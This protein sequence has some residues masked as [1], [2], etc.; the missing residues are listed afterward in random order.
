MLK[1]EKKPD[2]LP[3]VRLL[4]CFHI[5]KFLQLHIFFSGW[6]IINKD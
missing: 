5:Q 2:R 6:L 1:T 3:S 4:L